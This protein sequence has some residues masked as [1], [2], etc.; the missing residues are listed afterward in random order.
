MSNRPGQF[1]YPQV[2]CQEGNGNPLPSLTSSLMTG[3]WTGK[4]GSVWKTSLCADKIFVFS[5]L[6]QVRMTNDAIYLYSVLLFS[7]HC[8]PPLSSSNPVALFSVFLAFS[9]PPFFWCRAVGNEVERS[10]R[11]P[12]GSAKNQMQGDQ[13]KKLGGPTPTPANRTLCVMHCMYAT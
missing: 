11:L 6:R 10:I 3:C 1:V 7:V 9:S 5:A 12:R 2:V 8:I 4:S 13:K